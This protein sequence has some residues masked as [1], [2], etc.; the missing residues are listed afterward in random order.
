MIPRLIQH[1]DRLPVGAAADGTD[2][3]GARCLLSE[4]P[5]YLQA[6]EQLSSSNVEVSLK[7]ATGV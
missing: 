4:C 7:Y 3:I 1:L 2:L 5:L 6:V